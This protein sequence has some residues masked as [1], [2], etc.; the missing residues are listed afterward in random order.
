MKKLLIIDDDNDDYNLLSIAIREVNK[1]VEC[2]HVS[3]GD[4]ALRQLKSEEQPLPSLIL[5]DLNMAPMH[6]E[7]C[8]EEIKKEERLR[9]IP[10]VVY[11]TSC[12]EKDIEDTRF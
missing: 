8:L 11:S 6:G 2:R 5:L 10:I 9:D 3:D 1:S 12:Y 4:E 7:Q